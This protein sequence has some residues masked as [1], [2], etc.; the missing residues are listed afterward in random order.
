M[1]PPEGGTTN[2]M[3]SAERFYVARL[4]NTVLRIPPF[5]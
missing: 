1:I 5:W 3:Y 4:R 2:V